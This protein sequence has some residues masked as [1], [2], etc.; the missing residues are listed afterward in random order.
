L[1]RARQAGVLL[2][3]KILS[4]LGEA[5][6]PILL[7]RLLSKTDV[8]LLS[9]AML[10]YT[11][12]ALVLTGAFPATL[13]YYLPTRNKPERRAIAFRITWIMT[14]LGALLGLVLL[15]L[16]GVGLF[17]SGAETSGVTDNSS[18][19]AP[20]TLVY[21]LALAPYPLGDL[22]SRLLPNLLVVEGRARQAA[23]LGVFRAVG[24]ALSTL[25]PV[26]LGLPLHAVIGSVSAFGVL[27][28]IVLLVSLR[29]IY[30][31][32]ERVPVP[33][34]RKQIIVFTIPLGITDVVGRL[35]AELDRFLVGATFPATRFAEYRAA[36]WQ[37]PLIREVP[38]TVGRVDT[39]H[40]ARLFEMGRPR[41]ALALWRASIEKV[42]LLVVPL[43]GVFVIAAEEVVTL[44]FTDE[45]LG[46]APVFRL[47]SLLV[48]ARVCAF[49]SVIVAAGKPGYVLQ[50][51]VF[52][53]ASNVVL[54]LP[55]LWLFGFIGPAVGTVTA[56]IPMTYFYCWCI[57]R[58]AGV[59]ISETF[60]LLAYARVLATTAVASV[61]AV[62]IK[63]NAGLGA[64]PTLIACTVSLLACFALLGSLTRQIGPQ[65]WRFLGN[66][67]RGGFARA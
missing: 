67:L 66:W 65:D 57:A 36:A 60:P 19:F 18:L 11:T 56:F 43:A 2:F 37:I 9:A 24:T 14:G 62:L 27:N 54:S 17:L 64:G 25:F 33:I 7:I 48:L 53:L 49:G 32:V 51:A 26:A 47:Y 58:A 50:A 12:L 4:S 22:P 39:P 23:A 55:A 13:M 15:G 10:I 41:E 42:S 35:N 30:Q 16:G 20:T 34:S 40:L 1:V 61:P 5:V 31:R 21:L 52:S 28:G 59:R 38:Y 45:Y 29:S 6:A 44:L 8:G 46:A 63:L 3:G